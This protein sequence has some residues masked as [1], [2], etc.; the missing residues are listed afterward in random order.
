MI[1]E[2]PEYYLHG[3]FRA[4]ML[5]AADGRVKREWDALCRHEGFNWEN[6]AYKCG[7]SKLAAMRYVHH[8]RSN[9]AGSM[10][11]QVRSLQKRYG[12]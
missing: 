1:I 12:L 8:V 10:G 9:N 2:G 6:G 3:E 11:F 5:T 4:C 7:R